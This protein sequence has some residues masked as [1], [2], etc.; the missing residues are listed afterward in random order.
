MTLTSKVHEPARLAVIG[1]TFEIDE[2]WRCQCGREHRWGAYVAAHWDA[3]LVHECECGA[4]HEF[5]SGE[6]IA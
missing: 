4:T 3:E 2:V 6:V 1:E 5:I